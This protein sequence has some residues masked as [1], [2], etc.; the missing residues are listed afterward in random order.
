MKYSHGENLGNGYIG[1]SSQLPLNL[2]LFQNKKFLQIKSLKNGLFYVTNMLVSDTAAH[3]LNHCT[4][5][6]VINYCSYTEDLG[7][8]ISLRFPLSSSPCN[9]A[10]WLVHGHY[11]FNMSSY[12]LFSKPTTLS[13]FNLGPIC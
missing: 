10:T 3:F 9:V 13:V 5:S 6:D 7:T 1:P 4:P 2:H 12:I 8:F 11:K